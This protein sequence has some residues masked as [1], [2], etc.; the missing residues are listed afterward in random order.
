MKKAL[1]KIYSKGQCDRKLLYCS[2]RFLSSRFSLNI[3]FEVFDKI[4][5]A[6]PTLRLLFTSAISMIANKKEILLDQI[7]S[8][9]LRSCQ[10]SPNF[11]DSKSVIDTGMFPF[12]ISPK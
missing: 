7:F 3:I 2:F 8:R 9:E 4:C 10:L 11:D 1:D 6:P 12:L 5:F